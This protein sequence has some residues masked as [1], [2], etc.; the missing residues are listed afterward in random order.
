MN[1]FK[2]TFSKFESNKKNKKNQ[3][4]FEITVADK[5]QN[6]VIYQD[7][8]VNSTIKHFCNKFKLNN[9][10]KK[11]VM[12]IINKKLNSFKVNQK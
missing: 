9:Y 2:N 6:L 7:E 10:D 11:Q 4:V 5:P 12:K 1:N 8:D 3:Y